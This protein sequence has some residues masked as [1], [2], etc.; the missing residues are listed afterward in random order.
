MGIV[1]TALVFI[2]FTYRAPEYNVSTEVVV[3][4]SGDTLWKIGNYYI[5]KQDKYKDVRELIHY[6][7]EDNKHLGKY[8]VP[9]DKV[10]VTLYTR[11]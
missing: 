5:D 9:G 8:L 1:V 3:V 10:I 7:K 11:K 6:I 2:G 4:T